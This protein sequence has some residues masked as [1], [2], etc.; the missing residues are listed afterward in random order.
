MGV[1]ENGSGG[2][3]GE[4]G[5]VVKLPFDPPFKEDAGLS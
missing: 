4:G 5:E 3:V 2:G 1:V